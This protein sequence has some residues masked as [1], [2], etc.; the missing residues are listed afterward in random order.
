MARPTSCSSRSARRRG[1]APPRPSCAGASSARARVAVAAARAAAR[2]AHVRADRPGVGAGR[3]RAAAAR[4][5]RAS[6]SRG[7]SCTRRST[8]ALLWPGPGAIRY[9]APAAGNRP[10]RHGLWQ[11]PLERRR[12]REAPLLVPQAQGALPRRPRRTRPRVVVPIP[13]EPSGRLRRRERDIAAITYARQPVEEGPRPRARARGRRRGAPGEEL[14]VAGVERV[15]GRAGRALG[16]RL[17]AARSTARCC[18]ARVC[19]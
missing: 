15:P 2:R 11:R 1:C 14:V 19:T 18:A 9:D 7:R 8:A 10:G 5:A 4:G 17:R 3:A 12:L 6:T 13:V 16:G